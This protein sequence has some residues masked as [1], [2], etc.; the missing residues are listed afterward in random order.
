MLPAYHPEWAI[1][2]R[3]RHD[4]RNSLRLGTR[5]FVQACAT[6]KSIRAAQPSD[7]HGAELHN[8]PRAGLLMTDS[9]NSDMTLCLLYVSLASEKKNVAQQVLPCLRVIIYSA[10]YQSLITRTAT[11]IPEAAHTPHCSVDQ[12]YL[13]LFRARL[14]EGKPVTP[15]GR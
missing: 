3:Q 4:R 8:I 7:L 2:H 10:A 11:H 15:D 12:H 9:Y 14:H 6:I 1:G 13:E 5:I